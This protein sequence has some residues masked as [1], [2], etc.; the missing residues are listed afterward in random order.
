MRRAK[1]TRGFTLIEMLVVMGVVGLI[2]ALLLPAVQ[3]SRE[4]ARKL[5]C[6]N[7]VKQVCLA[8]HAY[9]GAVGRFP[10]AISKG[11]DGFY[12]GLYVDKQFSMIAAVLPYLDQQPLF[13]SINFSSYIADPYDPRYQMDLSSN[14]TAMGTVLEILLCPSDPAPPMGPKSTAGTNIRANMGSERWGYWVG[15]KWA[16][17]GPFDAPVSATIDGLRLDGHGL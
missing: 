1:A 8:L 17:E 11:G 3:A 5:S 9:Q 16:K 15:P 2:A 10:P 7:N 6:G 4:A 12:N 13:S 14:A